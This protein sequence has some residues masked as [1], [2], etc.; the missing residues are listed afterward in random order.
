MI[1]ICL[2]LVIAAFVVIGVALALA[3]LTLV[4]IAIG[5]SGLSAVLLAIEFVRNRKNLFGAKQRRDHLVSDAVGVLGTDGLGKA[6]VQAAPVPAVMSAADSNQEAGSTG[7]T[8]PAPV[9]QP[10]RA[11]AFSGESAD[12]PP[13]VPSSLPSCDGHPD[14]VDEDTSAVDSTADEVEPDSSPPAEDDCATADLARNVAK[15][16]ERSADVTNESLV[17]LPGE[18]AAQPPSPTGSADGV[19]VP[20]AV[21]TAED[22]DASPAEADTAGAAGDEEPAEAGLIEAED[23]AQ[24]VEV[25][26]SAT[27]DPEKDDAQPAEVDPSATADPEKDD[28]QPAEADPSAT[29]DPEKDDAQPVE[30]QDTDADPRPPADDAAPKDDV[31]PADGPEAPSADVPEKATTLKHADR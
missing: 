5:I 10:V 1:I 29:A 28:A 20:P 19:A 9:S 25:D 18:G 8:A 2:V 7:T 27:A 12:R 17:D 26:P 11:A 16:D 30:A 31:G 4:Y 15:A 22:G 6:S 13:A 3:E 23:D 14:P 21:D 24:P